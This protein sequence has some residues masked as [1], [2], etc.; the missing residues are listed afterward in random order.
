MAKLPKNVRIGRNGR[1]GILKKVPR[2]LWEHPQYRD[3]SKVIERSTGAVNVTEG[4]KIACAMLQDLE[5]EFASARAELYAIE[6]LQTHEEEALPDE[7]HEAEISPAGLSA[8][9]GSK[10]PP[11]R[12]F[13]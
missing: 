8:A 13:Q 7:P 6:A 3:R 12:A 4:V 1:V 11:A 5:Q 2:D 10:P 9:E